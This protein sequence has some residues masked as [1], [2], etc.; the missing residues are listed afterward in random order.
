MNLAFYIDK[1]DSTEFNMQLFQLLNEA[2]AEYKDSTFSIFYNNLDHVGM[3]TN[4]AMFNATELWSFTGVLICVSM[5]NT[6]KALK[7]INKFKLLHMYD[8]DKKHNIFDILSLMNNEEITVIAKDE[9]DAKELYRVTGVKPKQ[10]E[11]FSV[12]KILE[13]I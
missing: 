10:L 5:E 12:E 4:F 2:V 9:K 3:A 6:A 8:D 11:G 13:V 1:L 7:V